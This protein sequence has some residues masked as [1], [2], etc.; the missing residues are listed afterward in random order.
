MSPM[1]VIMMVVETVPLVVVMAAPLTMNYPKS[2]AE[3]TEMYI[4][5]I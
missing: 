4:L 5:G 3:W 2:A 1:V